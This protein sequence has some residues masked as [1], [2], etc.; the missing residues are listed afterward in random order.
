[1]S[2][3]NWRRTREYRQ[4]RISIIRRDKVCQVCGSMKNRHAHHINHGTYFKEQR[5]SEDNG[6]CLC[7]VC[8]IIFHTSYKNSFRE[9][10]TEKD[11][12]N[13]LELLEKLSAYNI[14]GS[15]QNLNMG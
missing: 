3:G 14:L 8:H 5:F 2:N 11:F 12:L 10:C 4:W 7:G 1:M 9:K 6:V 15:R 13:F